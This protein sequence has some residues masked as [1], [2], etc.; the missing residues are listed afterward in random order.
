MGAPKKNTYWTLAKNFVKPKSYTPEELWLKAID[1]FEWN[2]KNPL[3][4][5]KA[6]GSGLKMTVNKLRAMTLS[7]FANFA[8]ISRDTFNEYEH[9]KEY[10]DICK[11]IRE[12]IYQQKIEGAA[13]DLLN[14]A[15]IAR[16]MGLADKKEIGGPG[17]GDVK[18]TLNL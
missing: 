9:D 6:F 12:I 5:Q 1:Y 15:I 14:P 10:S 13:A 2:E 7:G 3:K 17:G 11:R 8:N 4:E 16:E 18:I